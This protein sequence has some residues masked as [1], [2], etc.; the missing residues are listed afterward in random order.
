MN[1]VGKFIMERRLI[2]GRVIDPLNEVRL[3]VQGAEVV[4]RRLIY[5]Q[6]VDHMAMNDIITFTKDD[7][8]HPMGTTLEAE[9]FVFNREQLTELLILKEMEWREN[10]RRAFYLD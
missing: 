9:V 10:E 4:E 1:D 5:R 6:I 2:V 7:D 3:G 8:K